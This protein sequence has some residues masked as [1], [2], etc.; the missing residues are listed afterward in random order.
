M[1]TIYTLTYALHPDCDPVGQYVARS[2]QDV[3]N[4]Y[5][6]M[7]GEMDP[8]DLDTIVD[9]GVA[10]FDELDPSIGLTDIE[11]DVMDQDGYVFLIR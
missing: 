6:A 4:A 7:L 2:A 10:E 3:E 11:R 5:T 9:Y 1:A 8:E